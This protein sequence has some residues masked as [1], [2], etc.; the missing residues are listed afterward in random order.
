MAPRFLDFFMRRQEHNGCAKIREL[1]SDF[2]DNDL[3]ESDLDEVE[4]HLSECE[5]CAAFMDTLRATVALLRASARNE[6]PPGFRDRV[7]EHLQKS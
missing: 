1:L 4:R 6:A 7:R 5:P 3:S 2:L